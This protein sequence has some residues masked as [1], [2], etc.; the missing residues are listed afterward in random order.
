MIG[1][2]VVIGLLAIS[3]LAFWHN[4]RVWSVL[5]VGMNLMFATLLATGLFEMLANVLEGAVP[6][7][8]YYWDMLCFA[9]VFI[10]SFTIL[11]FITSMVSKTNVYF[12]PK[13]D[14]I[15]RWI[16][17][18][19]VMV[20]FAGTAGFIFYETMPE[21]PAQRSMLATMYLIDIASKGSLKPMIGSTTFD[22]KDFMQRQYT[23]NAGVY[24][25]TVTND[26][27]K[28]DGDSP[29]AQ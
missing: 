24:Y 6:V 14:K 12:D 13:P 5:I 23:R 7:M 11:M 16:V 26:S 3:A 15:A 17:S 22:T 19:I 18:I 20:G 28:F 10:L 2:W 21:K 1:F 9:L 4:M 27:W 29:N 8:A 25:E